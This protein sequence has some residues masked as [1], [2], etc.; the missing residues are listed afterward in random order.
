VEEILTIAENDNQTA[1]DLRPD[2]TY[3]RRHPAKNEEPRP[4]QQVFM[5]IVR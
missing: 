1:W 4:S 2:G 5:N 3:I